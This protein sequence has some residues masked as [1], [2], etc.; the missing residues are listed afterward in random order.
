MARGKPTEEKFRIAR[1]RWMRLLT[2]FF[3]LK[4]RYALLHPMLFDNRVEFQHDVLKRRRGF[5]TLQRSLFLSC[6]LDIY[7]LTVDK[8]GQVCIAKCIADL[9]DGK[10]T[11][12]LRAHY[13]KVELEA[14]EGADDPVIA[15]LDRSFAPDRAIKFGLDFD[16]RRERMI[17][18]WKLVKDELTFAKCCTVRNNLVAHTELAGAYF[19]PID[20]RELGIDFNELKPAIDLMQELIE[21]LGGLIHNSGFAWEQLERI[22]TSAADDFWGVSDMSMNQIVWQSGIRSNFP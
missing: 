2:E 14:Y 17:E 15:A 1:R 21:Q 4:E 3:Q 11:R 12:A 5:N 13:V 7:K 22:V 6:C 20:I 18:A 19:D 16:E 8:S 10:L 9:D